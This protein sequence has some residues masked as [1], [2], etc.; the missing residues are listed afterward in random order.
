[1]LHMS[2]AKSCQP[3]PKLCHRYVIIIETDLNSIPIHVYSITNKHKN[4]AN[5]TFLLNIL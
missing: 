3:W 4:E 1:M 5:E 2:G